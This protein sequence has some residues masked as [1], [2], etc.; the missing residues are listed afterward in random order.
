MRAFLILITLIATTSVFAQTQKRQP[1]VD[2]IEGVVVEVYCGEIDPYYV[3]DAC[4]SFIQTS[5]TFFGVVIEDYDYQKSFPKSSG[6]LVRVNTR[7]LTQVKSRGAIME[8]K[9]IN[10][11]AFYLFSSSIDAFTF[12]R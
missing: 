11:D 3:G 5:D 2:Y 6:R 1:A 4:I 8:L 12:V 7:F 10:R 9:Y